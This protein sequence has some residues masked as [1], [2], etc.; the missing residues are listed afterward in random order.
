MKKRFAKS[1]TII[2]NNKHYKIYT[3]YIFSFILYHLHLNCQI[4]V[5]KK[6]MNMKRLI[7]CY[8]LADYGFHLKSY[9]HTIWCQTPQQQ[10]TWKTFTRYLFYISVFFNTISCQILWERIFLLILKSSWIA[11]LSSCPQ[12]SIKRLLS[13]EIKV[14]LLRCYSSFSKGCSQALF[15]HI[16]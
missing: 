12:E 5:Y 14:K 13:C 8:W 6:R 2:C 1:L 11:S 15:Y 4:D 16:S 10:N 3:T 9:F 7:Y